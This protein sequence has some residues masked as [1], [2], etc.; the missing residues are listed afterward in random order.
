MSPY[1]NNFKYA[2]FEVKSNYKFDNISINFN[3]QRDAKFIC[4]ISREEID[5]KMLRSLRTMLTVFQPSGT[6]TI[7]KIISENMKK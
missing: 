1:K 4:E 7:D 3:H 6:T 2:V 5:D